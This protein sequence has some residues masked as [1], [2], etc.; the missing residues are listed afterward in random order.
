MK[1]PSS[2]KESHIMRLTACISSGRRSA[3]FLLG[4]LKTRYN[5]HSA[6]AR[7]EVRHFQSLSDSFAESSKLSSTV[8][9]RRTRLVDIR[10]DDDACDNDRACPAR[11]TSSRERGRAPLMCPSV[12]RRRRPQQQQQ[13]QRRATL[14]ARRSSAAGQ[15]I[16]PKRFQFDSPSARSRDHTADLGSRSTAS[17]TS[18]IERPGGTV[19]QTVSRA[20]VD[21]FRFVCPLDHWPAA[22]P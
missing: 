11:R 5:R 21:Q 3:R 9:G 19:N 20:T 14:C 13:C 7:A 8:T 12:G 22:A 1:T 15:R 16:A 10:V 6:G 18:M 17:A 2:K 4:L